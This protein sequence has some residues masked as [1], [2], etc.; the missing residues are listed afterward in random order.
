MIQYEKKK[1]LLPTDSPGLSNMFSEVKKF[2]STKFSFYWSFGVRKASLMS[3][4]TR[5]ELGKCISRTENDIKENKEV[6]AAQ[7]FE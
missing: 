7:Q 1:H 2:L 3:F 4:G 5:R 6:Y